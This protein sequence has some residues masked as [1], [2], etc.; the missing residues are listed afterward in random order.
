M[1]FRAFFCMHG[2]R[3]SDGMGLWYLWPLDRAFCIKS[4][5]IPI[6]FL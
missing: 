2:K 1:P 5:D 3:A 6:F 4:I